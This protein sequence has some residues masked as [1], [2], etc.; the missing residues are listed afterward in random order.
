LFSLRVADET[1]EKIRKFM[2]TFEEGLIMILLADRI[3][4]RRYINST[5]VVIWK[6]CWWSR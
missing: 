5:P 3:T 6:T 4:N 2:I 1:K